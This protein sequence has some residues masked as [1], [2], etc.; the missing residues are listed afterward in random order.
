VPPFN[1]ALGDKLGV[2]RIPTNKRPGNVIHGLSFV[3]SAKSQNNEAAWGLIK[4]F[5]TREAGEAQAKVVVPAYEGASEAWK[6]N[7]PNLNLQCFITAAGYSDLYPTP[8]VA[9]SAQEDIAESAFERLWL[10][11]GSVQAAMEALDRD[12]AAAAAAAE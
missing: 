2:V 3:M 6:R 1:D 11:G 4:A 7:Y 8:T 5:S 10:N 12:C 9:A